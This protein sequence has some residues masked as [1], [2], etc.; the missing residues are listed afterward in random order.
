[1]NTEKRGYIFI[2]LHY[3]FRFLITF[4]NLL[5]CNPQLYLYGFSGMLFLFFS[6]FLLSFNPIPSLLVL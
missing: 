5:I 1:M 6:T 3:F 2:I 4:H